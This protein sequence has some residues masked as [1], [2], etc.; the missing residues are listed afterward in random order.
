[1]KK[2]SIFLLI[3]AAVCA[4][5][6][7]FFPLEMVVKKVVNKYGSEVTGTDVSL[8]GFKLDLA[9]GTASVKQIAV[10][11]PAGYTTPNAVSLGE[12]SVKINM[13]SLTADTIIIDEINIQKPAVTYEM[14]SLTQNNISDIINN[15]NA[16]TASKAAP[17]DEDASASEPKKSDSSSKKVVI[18]KVVVSNGEV[19]GV[20]SVAPDVVSAAVMLPTITLTNIGESTKGTSVAESIAV[21]FKKILSTASSSVVNSNLSHLKDAVADTTDAAKKTANDVVDGVK[22]TLE[23]LNIFSK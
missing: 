10:A 1:M 4:L 16:Y 21:I 20:A 23:N 17:I 2:F 7:Y 15:V 14:K 22:G 11:N 9:N 8:Q 18:K 6:Y 12:I 3:I 19:N 13:K 5:V